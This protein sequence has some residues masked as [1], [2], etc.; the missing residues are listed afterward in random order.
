[1]SDLKKYVVERKR[2]DRDFADDFEE[3]FARLK[4]G[5]ML[6]KAR[7]AAGLGQAELANRLKTKKTA[8]SRIE[9]HAEEI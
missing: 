3:G 2:R 8:I 7:E 9:K 4:I 5:A 6:R 1:M